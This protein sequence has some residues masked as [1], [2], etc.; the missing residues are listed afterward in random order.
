MQISAAVRLT[1]E[2]YGPIEV[3]SSFLVLSHHV[4]SDVCLEANIQCGPA[5]IVVEL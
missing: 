2:I 3:T 1:V 4:V 5:T